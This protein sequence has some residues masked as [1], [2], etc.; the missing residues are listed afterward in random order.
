MKGGNEARNEGNNHFSPKNEWMRNEWVLLLQEESGE[1]AWILKCYFSK[2]GIRNNLKWLKIKLNT[3]FGIL[4]PC[5][6]K[7]KLLLSTFEGDSAIFSRV[8][9]ASQVTQMVRNLPA[10]AG[11]TGWIPESGR[12]LSQ[13]DL[14]RKQWQPT[15][16]F[17]PG[18]SHGQRILV[19]QSMKLQK[20]Q[21]RLSDR[22]CI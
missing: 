21:V 3:K 14:W 13:G 12:S 22:A 10:N 2:I 5:W 17:L 11:D 15:P 4:M 6:L 7:Y 9:G 19:L 16:A 18:K 20:S 1:R 8:R